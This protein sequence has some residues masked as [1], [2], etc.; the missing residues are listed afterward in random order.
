MKGLFLFTFYE[1]N[2]FEILQTLC[3]HAE[4]PRLS[5]EGEISQFHLPTF[6]VFFPY[7]PGMFIIVFLES[8]G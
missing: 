1:K 6:L 5:E 2:L 3:V 4:A 7:V 8:S